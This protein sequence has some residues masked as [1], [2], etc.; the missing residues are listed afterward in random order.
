MKDPNTVL[1]HDQE[2]RIEA[3]LKRIRAGLSLSQEQQAPSFEEPSH[4]FVP[5]AFDVKTR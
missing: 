5:G 3:T 2:K 1:T 4:V